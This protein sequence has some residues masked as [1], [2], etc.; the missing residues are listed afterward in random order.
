MNS[1]FYGNTFGKNNMALPYVVSKLCPLV[2]LP[3]C[4]FSNQTFKSNTARVVLGKLVQQIGVS[5]TFEISLFGFNKNVH[6][7]L[8]RVKKYPCFQNTINKWEEIY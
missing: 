2:H 5:Y 7:N 1:F 6:L 4:S 3:S 8:Y